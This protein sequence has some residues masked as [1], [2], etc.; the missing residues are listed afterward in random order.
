MCMQDLWMRQ[1]SKVSATIVNLGAAG[2]QILAPYNERRL[3]F[4]HSVTIGVS[5]T[6]IVSPRNKPNA[7]DAGPI[8]GNGSTALIQPTFFAPLEC[9]WWVTWATNPT[10]ILILERIMDDDVW[11]AYLK[12]DRDMKGR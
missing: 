12:Y 1:H 2:T 7:G 3:Y 9:E 10:Q 4:A 6:T 8:A 5:A 11:H